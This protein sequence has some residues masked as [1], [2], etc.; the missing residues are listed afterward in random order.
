MDLRVDQPLSHH[1]DNPLRGGENAEGCEAPTVEQQRAVEKDLE[2]PIGPADD[3]DVRV[4][5]TF[6][7]RRHTDGMQ[8]RDSIGA[9]TYLDARHAALAEAWRA[10][11]VATMRT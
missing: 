10:S 11:K 6:H 4:Q 8:A 3:F 1:F 7:A 5:L 2:L 9:G